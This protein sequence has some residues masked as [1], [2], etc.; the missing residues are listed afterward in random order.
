M[1]AT[2]VEV[3]SGKEDCPYD[4]TSRCTKGRCDCEK[5]IEGREIFKDPITGDGTKKSARGL[6]QVFE[7]SSTYEL[8]DS[9]NWINEGHGALGTIFKDGKF[10]NL[11]T[12][13]EIRARINSQL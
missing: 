6:L 1:K 7:E 13:D 2:Y 11:V 5:Q 3:K 12:Y 10:T 9:Q 4:F 8:R